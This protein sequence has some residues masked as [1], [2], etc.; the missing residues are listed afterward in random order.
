MP[1]VFTSGTGRAVPPMMKV[2]IVPATATPRN[3]MLTKFS[4]LDGKR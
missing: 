2:D 1:N 3:F 4:F